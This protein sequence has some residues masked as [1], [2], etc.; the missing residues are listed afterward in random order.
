MFKMMKNV[1]S[2]IAAG[3]VLATISTIGFLKSCKKPASKNAEMAVKIKKTK[4]QKYPFMKAINQY[5]NPEFSVYSFDATNDFT[6]KHPSGTEILIPKGSLVN[7]DGSAIS[8]AV[9][10]KYREFMNKQALIAA[11]IPMRLTDT[12]YN[13]YLI[14]S[15]MMEIYAFQGGKSLQIN[16]NIP[17]EVKLANTTTDKGYNAYYLDTNKRE[18]IETA[19]E[20]NPVLYKT[21]TEIKVP[22]K[23]KKTEIS[24]AD[25][26]AKGYINPVKPEKANK[27]R[28]QF[29]FKINLQS[30]PELNV[31]D[32]VMFEY[33]GKTKA[34]DPDHNAW[35]K[36][37]YWHEM[38]LEKTAKK[39]VYVLFLS[40]PD[41]KFKTTVKP[42]FDA[43]DMEYANDVFK[44]RYE[45]YRK[46]V[47]KQKTEKQQFETRKN[48]QTLITR[49]FEIRNF[50]VW[51]TDKLENLDEV[52]PLIV[53]LNHTDTATKFVRAYLLVNN[54]KG[55]INLE[56]NKNTISRFQYPTKTGA[57]ILLSDYEGKCY[58]LDKNQLNKLAEIGEKSEFT[59]QQRGVLVKTEEDLNRVM[60]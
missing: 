36:T 1:K 41:K 32:G 11:G 43:E 17:I 2:I 29:Q 31:Y 34:E 20:I 23:A 48:T 57:K 30:F 16:Q 18:W 53:K 33:V 26:L 10:V 46:F 13:K 52:K 6:L 22:K 35:V 51:N 21:V 37:Q 3:I 24:E 47:D 60:G 56:I 28:H 27:N 42:V 14:S 45:R 50:G 44:D 55:V 39:G 7:A 38:K 5:V 49:S 19:H 9:E 40:T 59:I 15:G 4:A 12:D 54:N 25:A 58:I 8:G